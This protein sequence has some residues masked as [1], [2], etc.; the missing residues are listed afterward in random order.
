MP[1]VV[2]R[3]PKPQSQLCT[4]GDARKA[5]QFICDLDHDGPFAEGAHEQP[6]EYEVRGIT[7]DITSYDQLGNFQIECQQRKETNSGEMLRLSC[8][9]VLWRVECDAIA[10]AAYYRDV[11]N[12]YPVVF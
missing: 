1:R 10:A 3:V 2:V 4:V 8:G 6:V 5:A 12:R 7:T 9:E 11:L